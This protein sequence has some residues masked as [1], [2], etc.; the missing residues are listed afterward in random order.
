MRMSVT[1]WSVTE[2]SVTEWSVISK[3][4]IK[5]IHLC[6]VCVSAKCKRSSLIRNALVFFCIQKGGCVACQAAR[7]PSRCDMIVPLSAAGSPA[8]WQDG[9]SDDLH[10]KCKRSLLTKMFRSSRF[11][12]ISLNKSNLSSTHYAMLAHLYKFVLSF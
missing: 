2:W 1:E 6:S 4:R 11:I 5:V 8:P 7:R 3:T 12:I 9:I 10:L